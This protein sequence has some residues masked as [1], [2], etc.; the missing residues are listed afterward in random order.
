MQLHLVSLKL[1]VFRESDGKNVPYINY[2][3]RALLF[4][5]LLRHV[6]F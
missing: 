1:Y 5:L 3:E 4:P 2:A 6:K